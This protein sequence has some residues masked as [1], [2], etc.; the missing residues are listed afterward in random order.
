[1]SFDWTEYFYLA[2]DV[3]GQQSAGAIGQEARQRCAM[4]RAYY[5]VFARARNHLRYIDGDP[6]VP[7]DPSAHRYVRDQ[8]RRSRDPRRRTLATLLGN[9]RTYRNQADY[10]NSIPAL[11]SNTATALQQ[12]AHAIGILNSL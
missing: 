3:I 6:N 2:Q 10:D 12:A 8:L 5:A 7:S 1:M 9:L 11:S 4:S